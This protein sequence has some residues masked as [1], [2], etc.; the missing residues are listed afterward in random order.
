M[1]WIDPTRGLARYRTLHR[2]LRELGP[3]G[4]AAVV[5]RSIG[6]EF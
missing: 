1:Y 3:P 6:F 4:L 5:L 2:T